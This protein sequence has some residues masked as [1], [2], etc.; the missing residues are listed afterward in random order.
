MKVVSL[1]NSHIHVEQR[2]IKIKEETTQAAK[3]LF[4]INDGN[5]SVWLF[6]SYFAILFHAYK[7]IVSFQKIQLTE[8]KT[9]E[10]YTQICF[11]LNM[12]TSK[13]SM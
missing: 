5:I 10:C 11:Q 7:F 6:K 1:I 8:S 12:K 9:L 4:R 2:F 13:L 3:I